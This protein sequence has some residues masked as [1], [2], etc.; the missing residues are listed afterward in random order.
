MENGQA[1]A[2]SLDHL[3]HCCRL[4]SEMYGKSDIGSWT[5]SDYVRLGYILYKK[6]NVQISPN[7][8]KRIFGKI[9]TDVRY[10][11]QKATRDALASYVG[12]AD[13]EK[14][15]TSAPGHSVITKRAQATQPYFEAI[16]PD[17]P[18][19]APVTTKRKVSWVYILLPLVALIAVAAFAGYKLFFAEPA[20]VDVAL[21]CQNPVGENPHSAA[22]VVRGIPEHF[23]VKKDHYTLDFGDSRRISLIEGDSLYSH[24]YEV[25]GRYLA[26]LKRNGV[27]LDTAS[28]YLKTN[29]WTATAKM[30]YD[31]T[32]VYPIDIQNL[33]TGTRKIVSALEVSRAG[34]D[35]NRTFFVEFINTQLT[36]IDADNFELFVKLNTSAPRA[37]VRCSQVRV[38][39]FGESSKHV[40]DVMKPGCTH[41]TDLQFSEV[42]KP[43]ELNQL[44][45]LGVDLHAGGTVALKIVDKHVRLFINAKQVFET[46]YKKPL[47]QV[48][49]LG[50]TFSG[51]G[52][53]HSVILKD[54]KTGK[55]FAGNFQ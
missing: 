29:G 24:Y 39:V 32:R 20:P 53:I 14:F 46:D 55:S 18:I 48:Y 37:G 11:P 8:L 49:G 30:M 34:V 13:W 15:V 21:V 28:V 52:A 27:M 35:T 43:G 3:D 38:T 33:L 17:E 19:L 1:R 4:V 6:T 51:I 26:I 22:F 45:F 12:Y 44:N 2:S 40:F 10:Y 16:L 7:T 41:W 23:D 54:G 50:I 25:P 31:T 42:V 9:K 47:K 5:N 36:G